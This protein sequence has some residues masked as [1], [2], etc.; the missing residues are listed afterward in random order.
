MIIDGAKDKIFS[1]RYINPVTF[2]WCTFVVVPFSLCS[3]MSFTNDNFSLAPGF[4]HEVIVRFLNNV[5]QYILY[6][7]LS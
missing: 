1:M 7:C 6:S 3:I 5:K 2:L 4:S